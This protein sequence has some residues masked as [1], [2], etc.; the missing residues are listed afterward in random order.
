MP[1][2]PLTAAPSERTVDASERRALVAYRLA[3]ALSYVLNPLVLPPLGFGL[4]GW[5]FGAGPIEIAWV[6]GL[7]LTFFCLVP[8]AYILWLLWRGEIETLEVR[9]RERRLKPFLVGIGS[10]AVGIGALAVVTETAEPLILSL[11]LLYPLNTAVIVL[12]NLR[13]KISVHMTSMAGFVAVLLFVA[14]T[15]WEALPEPAEMALE[16]ATVAP[17]VLLLPL[18]M[19]ARVR[20]GAH[21]PGQVVAGTLFGFFMP[22]VELAVVVRA[23][24]L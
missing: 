11:A 13:W 1:F 21:T 22:L 3:N 23:L 10:Y 6:V 2:Q 20:V 12:I 15:V 4:I 14:L 7:S 16:V 18:L 5:H 17:L 24:G 9:D 19:W 8:L